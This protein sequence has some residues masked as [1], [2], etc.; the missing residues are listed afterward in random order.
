MPL[1]L[2]SAGHAKRDI[3]AALAQAIARNPGVDIEL[4]PP[5]GCHP[6]IL[7][8]VASTSTAGRRLS[9]GART[10]SPDETLLIL[11]GR[12]SSDAEAIA[13]MRRLADLRRAVRARRP[14]PAVESA[15]IERPAR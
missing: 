9:A 12:G 5:L 2:F 13:E 1:V 7:E 15:R 3:P 11:V 6:A 8:L 14:W 10:V 4:C